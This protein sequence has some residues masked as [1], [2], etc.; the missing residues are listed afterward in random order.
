MLKT[1]AQ[2]R[3]QQLMGIGS[4]AKK[5]KNY[6]GAFDAYTEALKVMPKDVAAQRALQE[7]QDAQMEARKTQP[8]EPRQTPKTTPMNAEKKTA[9]ELKKVM[10]LALNS[11]PEKLDGQ[12]LL[13]RGDLFGTSYDGKGRY[14][15]TVKGQR[16]FVDGSRLRSDG[17]NF[18]LPAEQKERLMGGMKLD[19]FYPVTMTVSV[20]QGPGGRWLGEVSEI[21]REDR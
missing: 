17:I 11:N 4:A 16:T 14:R 8:F 12:T 19:Q 10:L 9:P 5:N 21:K 13:V 6:G 2:V 20:R 1:A 7:A 15:L 3:Y 18:I